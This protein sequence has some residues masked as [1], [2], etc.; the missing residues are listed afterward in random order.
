MSTMVFRLPS[1][2]YFEKISATILRIQLFTY[3][4]FRIGH[5]KKK[6]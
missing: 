3:G 6:T 4:W 1:D 2:K 5:A